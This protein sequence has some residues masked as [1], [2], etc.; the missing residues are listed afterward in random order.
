[1]TK[2]ITC[3]D[4]LIESIVIRIKRLRSEGTDPEEI[5]KG[6][7]AFKALGCKLRVAGQPEGKKYLRVRWFGKGDNK[8]RSIAPVGRRMKKA[9]KEAGVYLEAIHPE[10]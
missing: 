4:D 2:N 3:W 1:M 9:L 5:A 10:S 8:E 6:L 7:I